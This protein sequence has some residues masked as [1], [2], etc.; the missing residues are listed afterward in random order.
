[1][2][3]EKAELTN[4][5]SKIA[6]ALL[7]NRQCLDAKAKADSM[8]VLESFTPQPNLTPYLNHFSWETQIYN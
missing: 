3:D 8:R 6:F 7:V 4:E 1:V 2:P 5:G